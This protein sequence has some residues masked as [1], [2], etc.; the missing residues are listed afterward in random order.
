VQA[1]EPGL[2]LGAETVASEQP[3]PA[4]EDALRE[5]ISVWY[6]WK[7]CAHTKPRDPIA[8]AYRL[9]AHQKGSYRCSPSEAQ[10]LAWFAHGF[11]SR[12]Q[13]R[14]I[15]MVYNR[16]KGYK[17]LAPGATMSKGGGSVSTTPI[18]VIGDRRVR[19]RA[20]SVVVSPAPEASISLSAVQYKIYG[21][22]RNRTQ[23]LLCE[24]RLL[25]WTENSTARCCHGC[26][27]KGL[28]THNKQ[29]EKCTVCV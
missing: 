13:I 21:S 15:I 29:I 25:G 9:E 22:G 16:G 2:A 27:G 8:L 19:R 18:T 1:S 23:T 12:R 20:S 3:K 5:E 10:R 24:C 11:L 26:G 6:C 28:C 14:N 17:E 4:D 7:A